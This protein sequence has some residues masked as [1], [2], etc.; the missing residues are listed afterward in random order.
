MNFI[1]VLFSTL[2]KTQYVPLYRLDLYVQIDFIDSPIMVFFPDQLVFH[3]KL[4]TVPTLKRTKPYL[5]LV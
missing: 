2:T 1:K 4:Y 5:V 3:R